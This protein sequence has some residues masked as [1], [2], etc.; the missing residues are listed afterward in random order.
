MPVVV[1]IFE[2][3]PQMLLRL[4]VFFELVIET[5]SDFWGVR[6]TLSWSHKHFALETRHE[7]YMHFF[8][9]RVIE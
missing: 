6:W 3:L 7:V 5:H 1:C 8:G 4:G 9:G 2:H